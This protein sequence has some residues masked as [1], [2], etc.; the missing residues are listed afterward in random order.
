MCLRRVL[1]MALKTSSIV[2]TVILACCLAVAQT[3][4]APVSANAADK[5]QQPGDI[6]SGGKIIAWSNEVNVI[7]TVTDKHGKF[8][9]D[10]KQNQF[11]VLDNNLP[12]KQIMN[13]EAETNLPLRVG[14]LI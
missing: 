5:G 14:L 7:F 4:P 12:P 6:P 2:L 10:M 8:V 3:Q 9:K 11:K 1:V 13:F